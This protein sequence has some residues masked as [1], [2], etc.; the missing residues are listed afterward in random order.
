MSGDQF[1]VETAIFYE[2]FARPRSGDDD[3]GH[4][5]P[6]NVGHEAFRI[7]HGTKLFG[8][9]FN[10]DAAQEVV[11][12]M[13]AGEGKHKI[14]LEANRAGGGTQN[15]TVVVNLGHT[16]IKVSC[17]L[18]RFDAVLYIRAHP[19]FDVGMYLRPATDER[20]AC[21]MTPQVQSGFGR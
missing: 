19:V 5:D 2:D 10:A 8:R 7:A 9:K 13:V 16:A 12:W 17:D 21:A 11:V 6:G 18:A 1:A 3:A 14:I 4:V 15:D 20:D